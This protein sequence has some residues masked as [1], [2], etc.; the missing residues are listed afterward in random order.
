MFP[1]DWIQETIFFTEIPQQGELPSLYPIRQQTVAGPPSQV[2]ML[3]SFFK[4]KGF[5]AAVTFFPLCE[6]KYLAERK[7]KVKGEFAPKDLRIPRQQ[8]PWI[9]ASR[10]LLSV[11]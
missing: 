2:M 6:Q 7:L 5:P 3:G 8:G 9:K 4:E 1:Q 11:P 10:S